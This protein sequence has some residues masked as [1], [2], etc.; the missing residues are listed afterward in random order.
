MFCLLI[1]C[2]LVGSGAVPCQLATYRQSVGCLRAHAVTFNTAETPFRKA[3]RIRGP[4]VGL[5]VDSRMQT[6][7]RGVG[8]AHS[9]H[10]HSDAMRYKATELR[11][12]TN[13][14]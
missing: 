9:K 5:H 14:T 4:S 12:F 8:G 11:I 7:R 3:T 1:F 13:T 10:S 2:V 6:R